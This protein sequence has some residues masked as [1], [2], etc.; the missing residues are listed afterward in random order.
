MGF[1]GN[2]PVSSGSSDTFGNLAQYLLSDGVP[3]VY[4]FDNCLQDPGSTIEVLG[5]DL[6]AFLNSIKYDTGDQVPKID[7]VAHSMGGL[8]VRAYLAGLQPATAAYLPP[9]P[10]LVGKLVMIATPNWGSYVAG[11][12]SDSIAAGTQS[13]ELIPGS[14]M[15]WNLATW[16]QWGD[17]LQGVNA[18]AIAGNAGTYTNLQAG[19]SFTNAGDGMVSL[20]SASLG[21]VNQDLS[22]TRIVPYCHIDPSA[23]IVS[24]LGAFACNAAGIANV[25][26]TSHLTG[27]I[28][29][30]FLSGT[31]AWQSLGSSPSANAY[32]AKDGTLFFALMNASG[33]YISDLTQASWGGLTL[34]SGG[35]SGTI[36]YHDMVFGTGLFTATSQSLGNFNCFTFTLPAGY[37]SAE[38]CKIAPAIFSVT[39]LAKNVSG[40]S[41]NS[42]APIT[43]TG[44]GFQSQCVNCQVLAI[45][46][47]SRTS[48][49]LQVTS[50]NNTT[51]VANLP[52]NLSGLVTIQVRA[53]AGYDNTN[54]MAVPLATIAVAPASLQFAA[55][56][57]GAPPAAQ[58][59]QM[60]NSGT[61]TLAW[62][63]TA[64]A[65][66]LSVTPASGTA[67]ST[68]SVS[69]SPAS[70]TA[71]TY[72]GTVQISAGASNSPLSIGVTFTV[73]QVQASL[74]VAP[75]VLT[76]QYAA[77]GAIP[78]AQ[79]LTISNAGAGTLA[80]TA[81]DADFWISLSAQSGTASS[82]LSVSVNPGNL[83]PGTYTSNVQIA[84]DGATGSPAT[85]AVTFVVQGTQAPGVITSVA[86]AATI[87][88]GM[89]PATWVSIFGTNLSQLTYVWQAA[90]FV[91]GTLP[92]T[93]H[94][95]SVT[96]NGKPAYVQYISP[97]QIN[98]LAPDDTITGPVQVQVTTAKQASNSFTAQESQVAPAF[99]TFGGT[100]YVAAEHNNYSYLGPTSLSAPGYPFT[101]AAP[102][103]HIILYGTGFGATNPAIPTAQAAFVAAQLANT[104]HISIGGVQAD[105]GFAGLVSPGLYQFNVTVPSLPDGDA[106]VLASINGAS[107][108]TGVSIP[109][110][111]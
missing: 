30:S 45:P 105:V 79:S 92:T 39:P 66:W 35:Y 6:A 85:V 106:A 62:T 91:G 29:R 74:A 72:Q 110:Q 107:S 57:G 68:L 59:I 82:T 55:T 102:G 98:V 11:S 4:F 52:G 36:F 33:A 61:G 22:T 64:S 8:I 5:N 94:G 58:T 17:D 88:P 104:V 46:A 37:G 90:D 26:N 100:N 75:Q 65:S 67:P 18:I 101:P 56:A 47:G 54:I 78:P 77:G 34:P 42:G 86:N 80:W 53:V 71:G 20:T 31:T 40:R 81:A 15:L 14:A 9:T 44:S 76:F 87:K 48:T 95:V 41:V 3:A 24:T 25:S 2:C 23:F 49:P 109:I 1:T 10:T 73:T 43:I 50:W 108:Q 83:A 97:V 28:V 27:Q 16:N 38:R 13:A 111:R 51:I 19:L 89:A 69:V 93:L 12:Y 7:L 60:T 63:A 21:F 32:M 99:F 96:I 70:L 84:A 103:E